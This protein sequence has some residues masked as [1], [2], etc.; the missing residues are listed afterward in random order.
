MQMNTVDYKANSLQAPSELAKAP[1]QISYRRVD[2]LHLDP[3]NARLHQQKQV[4]QIAESIKAFGFNVP[5]LTDAAGQVI[6]GH[7]RLLAARRLGLTEAP[8]I[9]IEHL[10]APQRRAFM[11]ADNRLTEISQWDDQL[12][13]EQL[14]ELSELDLSF[15]LEATGFE[16]GEIDLR[17]E[18]LSDMGARPAS[19]DDLLPAV[20]GPPVSRAGDLWI[21]G[22]HKVLCASALEEI[23]YAAL[24]RSDQAAIAF[25][26][27]P[28]NVPIDGHVSGSGAIKHREF[29]MGAGEMDRAGFTRFLETALCLMARSSRAGGL[30]YVC[31]DWRH[32]PELLAGADGAGLQTVN[33]CV[34]MKPNAGMGSF[35]RSQHELVFVLKNGADPHLNNIELGRYG[36]NRTNVWSYA[37]SPGF[38]RPGEEGRLAALHPTVKPVQM[39]ADAILDS[40][41]R[42]EIVLDPFLGSG[43]TLIAAER[44]GRCCF[45]LE[46]DPLYVDVIVRRW[47]AYSGHSAVHAETGRSF[48]ETEADRA[49]SIAGGVR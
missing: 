17:I 13:A 15:D 23:G 26:D 24:M 19:A 29:A 28:Y 5:I 44:V 11:I 41:R 35:Y 3:K 16:M 4:R 47:Q 32:I 30:I 37:A 36:R 43:T 10:T 8:T 45:G 40:T 9:Q 38:G 27:P 12:L 14:K 22:G 1:L 18:S 7:G 34:W 42:G 25:T 6:A 48:E 33:L 31:M 49:H 21:L 39:V 46:I 2:E 20:S